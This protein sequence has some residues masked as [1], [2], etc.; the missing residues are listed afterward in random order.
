MTRIV[1]LVVATVLLLLDGVVYGRWTDRWGSAQPVD[2]AVARLEQIPLRIGVWQ[3]KP[4]PGSA[5]QA[6]RAGCAGCWVR[7]YER[8]DDGAVVDVMLACGRPGPLAVHTP[9][10]CYTGSGYTQSEPA[11]QFAVDLNG[12]GSA[13]FWKTRFSKPDAVVPLK[14]Q[15]LWA[16][17][18]GDGWRAVRNPRLEFAG[19]RVLYKL[20]V[21]REMDGRDD[22]RD[23]RLS[24]DFLTVF[25]PAFDAALAAE[26]GAEP[27]PP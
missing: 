3:G 8:S 27:S 2:D 16:W 19:A 1:L 14:L 15:L 5:E 25:M 12:D 10:V 22:H 6:K 23:D 9:D 24:S 13:T 21:V 7:R 20:Y 17:H 18:S 11:M 26:P 4:V